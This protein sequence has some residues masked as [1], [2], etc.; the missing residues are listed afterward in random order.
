MNGINDFRLIF[1]YSPVLLILLIFFIFFSYVFKR[2]T[3]IALGK[4]E[5]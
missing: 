5:R 2:I 4:V 3:P 1:N